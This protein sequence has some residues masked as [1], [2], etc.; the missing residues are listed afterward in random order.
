M[1]AAS[2]EAI[3]AAHLAAGRPREA[4]SVIEPAARAP[5]ASH[6]VLAR[7]A[8]AL[9]ALERMEE[10]LAARRL[11]AE[12][13]PDSGV[14]WHNLASALCDL[15]GGGEA[16]QACEKA[17]ATGL[18]A[19]ETWLVYGRAL[20]SEQRLPEALAAFDQA[21]RR[22]PGYPEAL[23]EKATLVWTTTGDLEQAA[24]VFPRGP[25]HLL[26]IAALYKAAGDPRRAL[27]L[28]EEAARSSAEPILLV[29]LAGLAI[30]IGE[31]D[32]ALAAAEAALRRAP[33][34]PTA[35][36]SWAAACLAA[37]LADEAL[38]AGRRL[39]EMRPQNQGALGLLA[40]AARLTDA[41]EYERLYDYDAFVRAYEIASPPGWAT[42][43]AFLA[44]LK[45]SLEAL[46]R[47]AVQPAAQS[48]RDGT[49][50][51]MDLRVSDDPVLRGFFAAI[52]PP[53]RRYMA[54]LGSGEDPLRG[55]NT[56]DYALAGCWSIR[57]RSGG[58]HVDHMHPKGWLSSAFYVDVPEVVRTSG[59]NEGWL[60]F[61]RP[62]LR[63]R[64]PLE[65]A[66]FVQP[67]PGRLVLF[68]S[69]MWHGTVPFASD[70][71]RMTVAF[72]VVPA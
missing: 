20:N 6:M 66:R 72:D 70:E 13:F 71:A 59:A 33:G 69:Y 5:D 35:L 28:L 60:Q 9:K 34:D 17:L 44:D 43:E 24:A 2:P 18:D 46:H 36:Q 32:K 53:I 7:W 63:T 11:A 10:C 47:T 4:L 29:S 52:D 14:A 21:L 15:G 62:S 22:R 23:T 54:E 40:V 56:G 37:G 48:L 65:P 12:R 57:L 39:V 67:E 26:N 38:A 51:T 41:P 55:R 25:A 19:A 27:A 42:R 1:N 58:H 16:V 50:T 64:P 31:N 68:P 49:Q 45:A 30:T 61:G 3:A 8:S